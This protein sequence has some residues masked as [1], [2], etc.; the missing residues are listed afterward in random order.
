MFNNST[1]GC[2]L[3]FA[4]YGEVRVN[5]CLKCPEVAKTIIKLSRAGANRH[6][7]KRDKN[8]FQQIANLAKCACVQRILQRAQPGLGRLHQHRHIARLMLVFQHLH[9]RI[10]DLGPGK[11]L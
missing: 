4:K 1:S 5:K 9:M 10:R 2:G 7:T 8:I 11:Y 6:G 3:L